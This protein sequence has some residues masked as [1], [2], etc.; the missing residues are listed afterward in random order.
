MQKQL[1]LFACEG[2]QALRRRLFE[3]SQRID[4]VE[5]LVDSVEYFLSQKGIDRTMLASG[6]K[7]LIDQYNF[8]H[9]RKKRDERGK[10]P[11]LGRIKPTDL[12][13]DAPTNREH[14]EDATRSRSSLPGMHETD[15]RS[16][17]NTGGSLR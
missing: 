17:W 13:S 9:F 5:K 8:K 6:L 12:T 2:C 1:E 10:N 7:D 15:Q 16:T 14:D 11:R 3:D 4:E